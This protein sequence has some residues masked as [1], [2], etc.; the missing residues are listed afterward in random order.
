MKVNKTKSHFHFDINGSL[1]N[2]YI[3]IDRI[4]NLRKGVF[5]AIKGGK[6]NR[7]FNQCVLAHN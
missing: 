6:I 4:N 1:N 5:Y 2:F 7:K 3:E